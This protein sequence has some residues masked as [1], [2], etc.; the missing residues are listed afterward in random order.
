MSQKTLTV[1]GVGV[2]SVATLLA[3]SR[4][5]LS[6]PET[7][8][9]SPLVE[10]E[11]MLADRDAEIANLKSELSALRTTNTA[12]AQLRMLFKS[13]QVWEAVV[14]D[15]HDT[16]DVVEFIATIPDLG[17]ANTLNFTTRQNPG[18]VTIGDIVRVE[19]RLKS[20]S[21][22]RRGL[23]PE[24]TLSDASILDRQRPE[25]VKVPDA[26]K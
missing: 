23:S 24:F 11:K 20:I 17:I 3:T 1:V 21:R 2:I 8:R 16:K 9:A 26:D 19:A 6:E 10:L 15:R 22:S 18:D 12:S 14:T 13:T 7:P 4:E 5:A 25:R